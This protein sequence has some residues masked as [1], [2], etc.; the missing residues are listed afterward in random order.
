MIRVEQDA[1]DLQRAVD[2]FVAE[3]KK[4]YA[5]TAIKQLHA[6][7]GRKRLRGTFAVSYV[8]L[9]LPGA[10]AAATWKGLGFV[11]VNDGL[12]LP[13]R[14][15]D[16]EA[17]AETRTFLGNLEDKFSQLSDLL[18]DPGS[19]ADEVL[20]LSQEL[21]AHLSS[22]LTFV[23]DLSVAQ[24]IDVEGGRSQPGS[25]SA[26]DAY[27]QIV[28][29]ARDA[30]RKLEVVT[31]ALYDDSASVFLIAQTIPFGWSSTI[32]Q[33]R[34]RLV[35]KLDSLSDLLRT[36]ARIT[37]NSLEDI[38]DIC[39][40]QSESAGLF[41]ESMALRMSRMSILDGDQRLSNFFGSLP[42]GPD[43][44][45]DVVDMEIAFRKPGV[46]PVMDGFAVEN[47]QSLA[48]EPEPEMNGLG[49]FRNDSQHSETLVGDSE[50][51]LRRSED[52]DLN[53]DP[54]IEKAPPRAAKIRQLLG[55]DVPERIFDNNDS[56]PWYLRSDN[57][58]D[59]IINPDGGIRAGTLPALVERLT[60]HEYGDPVFIRT[61]LMTYKSFTT[62]DQLL[63]LLIERYRMKPPEGLSP[64]ELEEWSKLKQHVVR[65]RVL[66]THK[67]MVTDDEVL[68]KDEIYILD[69]MKKFL[70]EPDVAVA[71]AAKNLLAAVERKKQGGSKSFTATP[72]TSFP[73]PSIIPKGM[74]KN[75]M[76]LLEID[77]LE[78][79]RQL[80][81]LESTLYKRIRPYECLQRA[82][83]S[84]TGENK[85][86]ITDVIQLT[87][88]IA[89]WVN[90]SILSKEDSRKRAA[91]VK[92]FITMADRCRS[93]QNYSSMAAI[94]S[95]LN[96]TPIRRLKRT[97]DQVSGRFLSQLETCESTLD[98]ARNFT[99]YKNTLASVNPPCIPFMGVYLTTLTFIQE[100]SK[101]KLPGNLIN[102]GKRQRAAEVIREIQHWQSKDYNLAP[103]TPV[104]AYIEDALNSFGDNVKWEDQFYNLS[105]EREPRER[106]DEKMARLLQE[107]GFL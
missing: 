24:D 2:N 30:L 89:N 84:K 3:V 29:R 90:S 53:G 52:D 12:G 4:Q 65:S 91:L 46:R 34:L 6:R 5:R 37:L 15:L 8:G 21:L 44:E 45:E 104:L 57:R 31:Q 38:M 54:I 71:P 92:H 95:G 77:P 20:G 75:K 73:P 85:D 7:I 106:E 72:S 63:D 39:V 70:L 49:H 81:L 51:T 60:S 97:W 1:A 61:F 50:T 98:A 11:N 23:S 36:D 101:D 82:R 17:L 35:H 16:G 79:A 80:T 64:P 66:N 74:N 28:S 18:N 56:K 76:K 10:G 47:P 33:E 27:L 83:E 69:R 25:S 107:S 14:N 41:R 58:D 26:E 94:V 59:L 86:H 100:G 55:P 105:L 99:N 43:E 103:L 13:K 102:F 32:T 62:L 96:S 88:K 42:S 19:T 9:G 87:N 40:E 68:E 78:L 93:L 22:T 48:S 67:T